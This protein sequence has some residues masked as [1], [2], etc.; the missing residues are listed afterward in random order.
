[1]VGS[2]RVALFPYITNEVLGADTRLIMV[3]SRPVALFPYITSNVL[4]AAT[5]LITVPDIAS[6]VR[7]PVASKAMPIRARLD[8][9]EDT[10]LLAEYIALTAYKAK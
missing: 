9:L 4:G 8:F 10:E 2:R 6:I 5:G 7:P 3:S 1:M